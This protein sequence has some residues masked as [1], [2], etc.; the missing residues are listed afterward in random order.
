MNRLKI[1]VSRADHAQG[2]DDARVVLVEYGDYQCPYCGAAAPIV[3][4]LQAALGADL[5]F[6]FRNFPLTEAHPDALNAAKAAEAAAARGKFWQMHD[7]LY[8]NQGDLS[9]SALLRYAQIVVPD[10]ERWVTDLEKATFAERV[11]ADFASGVRSG[12]N[13]TPTFYI[14]GRRFDGPY[15]ASALERAIVASLSVSGARHA[16]VIH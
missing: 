12:V 6:V 15:D 1:P 3:K 2:R 5:K 9:D 16:R 13:G 14:D 10:V 8:E 4:R 7:M 11:A